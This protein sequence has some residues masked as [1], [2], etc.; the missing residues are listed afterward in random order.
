MGVT[1]E[2]AAFLIR[3]PLAKVATRAHDPLVERISR[4]ASYTLQ[5]TRKWQG[6]DPCSALR[7]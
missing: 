5:R 1:T 2:R 4:A 3:S 6:S 7:S